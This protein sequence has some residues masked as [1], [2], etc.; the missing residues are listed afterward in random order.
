M[1]DCPCPCVCLTDLQGYF[2]GAPEAERE[3]A[4]ALMEREFSRL[5]RM[6]VGAINDAIKQ[7]RRAWTT[8]QCNDLYCFVTLRPGLVGKGLVSNTS[9]C[10]HCA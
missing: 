4:D 9:S 10:Q 7:V 2:A 8:L 3:A 1:P 5:A 6:N